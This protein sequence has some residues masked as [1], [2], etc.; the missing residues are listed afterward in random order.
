MSDS[1]IRVLIVDDQA[2]ARTGLRMV[3]EVEPDLVVVGEATDG[4]E[5]VAM[6]ASTAPDVILM[7]VRMPHMDGLEATRRIVRKDEPGPQVLVLTT[8]DLDEYVYEALLAGA[9]GFVLKDIP[10]EQLV[11]AIHVVASGDALLAPTITRRL[12]E[13]F[14]RRPPEVAQAP[15]ARARAAHAARGRDHAVRRPR[16]VQRG[17][18]GAGLS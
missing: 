14:V 1:P 2:L 12:I 7:D 11:E 8:F 3:L 13:E 9:S 10:P 18:R 15:A 4:E 17:D 5:A 16:P 6:A